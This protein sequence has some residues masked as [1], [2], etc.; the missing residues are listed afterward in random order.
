MS[1]P[2][3]YVTVESLNEHYPSPH[4]AVIAMNAWIAERRN[5]LLLRAS[6]FGVIDFQTDIRSW[7][8]SCDMV[9]PRV[10]Q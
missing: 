5:L 10:A 3:G 2:D 8:V 1:D 7:Q 4:E 9:L 6:I